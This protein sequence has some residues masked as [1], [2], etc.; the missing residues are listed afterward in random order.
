LCLSRD[1]A[2]KNGLIMRAVGD[3]M[4]I[5]PPLIMSRGQIDDLIALASKSLDDTLTT[6]TQSNDERMSL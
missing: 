1:A 4:I 3:S 5:S 2:L 6:Q